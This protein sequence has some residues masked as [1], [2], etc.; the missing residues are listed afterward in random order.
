M[1]SARLEFVAADSEDVT[2][3]PSAS[4]VLKI[5]NSL[6]APF[7]GQLAGLSSSNHVDLAD[8]TWVD[9]KMS[10]SFSGNTSGGVLAISNGT[11]TVDL[12]LAGDYTHSAWHLSKDSGTGTLFSDPPLSHHQEHGLFLAHHDSFLLIV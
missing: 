3:A 2:L 8:L 4:G 6:T 1:S 10:A 11:Q 5:D 7:T 9:G 12:N